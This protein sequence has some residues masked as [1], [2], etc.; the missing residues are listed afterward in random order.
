MVDLA[1]KE[2]IYTIDEYFAVEEQS[3]QKHEFHNGKIIQMA[4]GTIPHNTI[5]KNI[6]VA[7]ENWIII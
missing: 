6:I 3:R 7:L 4:G 2:R 5:K 1:Q